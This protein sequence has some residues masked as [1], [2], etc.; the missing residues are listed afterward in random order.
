M[1]RIGFGSDAG[2]PLVADAERVLSPVAQTIIS[3]PGAAGLA[4]VTR[5]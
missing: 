3:S 4:T 5:L 1:F 2:M